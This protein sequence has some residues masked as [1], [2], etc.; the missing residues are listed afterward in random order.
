MTNMFKPL[1]F[2][3]H[4]RLNQIYWWL[5]PYWCLLF[6]TIHLNTYC[7]CGRRIWLGT[8][9]PMTSE[10][11]CRACTQRFFDRLK[12]ELRYVLEEAE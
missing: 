9:L 12:Q 1:G 3:N 2:P 8:P 6:Y 5:R 10:V 7:R 11:R 4:P